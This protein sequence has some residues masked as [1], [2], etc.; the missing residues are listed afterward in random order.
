MEQTRLDLIHEWIKKANHDLGSAEIILKNGPEYTDTICFHCQ[1]ATEKYV[2]A[3][4]TFLGIDFQ[5]I[6]SLLY[7]AELAETK[8]P[9]PDDIYALLETLEDYA[10]DIRYP[11]GWSDPPP[12]DSAEAFETAQ[13]AIQYFQSKISI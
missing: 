2:K 13:K 11:T 9:I 3:Y 10:V 5:K 6:H 12:L 1:Q 4:L 8:A 7:L